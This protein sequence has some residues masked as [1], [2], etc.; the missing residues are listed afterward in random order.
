MLKKFLTKYV[1]IVLIF[2]DMVWQR[3]KFASGPFLFA[4]G[5]TENFNNFDEVNYEQQNRFFPTFW[6]FPNQVSNCDPDNFRNCQLLARKL[7]N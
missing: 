4:A 7:G 6:Q 2:S 5:K 3:I 1:C